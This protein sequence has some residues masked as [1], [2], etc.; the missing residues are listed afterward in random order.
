M[1]IILKKREMR[2]SQL[3]LPIWVFMDRW[4]LT[5]SSFVV[6]I[7]VALV[8]SGVIPSSPGEEW[9]CFLLFQTSQG[10]TEGSKQG[11]Q[12]EDRCVDT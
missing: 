6:T 5:V 11:L 10:Q 12:R 9:P 8:F 1:A 7:F 4:G 2:M 3:L